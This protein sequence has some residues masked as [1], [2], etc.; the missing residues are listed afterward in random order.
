MSLPGLHAQCSSTQKCGTCC[1]KPDRN[2]RYVAC[3]AAS[4]DQRTGFGSTCEAAKANY[5]AKTAS[6]CKGLTGATL[7]ACQ[8]GMPK[9]ITKPGTPPKYGIQTQKTI[10][11]RVKPIPITPTTP[12]NRRST[13]PITAAPRKSTP[14]K[15]VSRFPKPSRIQDYVVDDTT[16]DYTIPQDQDQD[17]PAL[18]T[19]FPFS[20]IWILVAAIIILILVM[21]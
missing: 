12:S 4:Y 5:N 1:I 14:I 2:I 17:E 15:L 6:R 20:P 13:G 9:N 10:S 19:P 16:N 11:E 21:R 8:T 18:T 7:R 3:G